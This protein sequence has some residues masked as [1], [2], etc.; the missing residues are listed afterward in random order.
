MSKPRYFMI[1]ADTHVTEARDVWTSRVPSKWKDRVPRVE[2][3]PETNSDVWYI[4]DRA[5]TI[6]RTCS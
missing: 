4:G 2:R 1:D 3:D 6:P 5:G